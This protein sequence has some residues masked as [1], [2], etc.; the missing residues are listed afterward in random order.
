LRTSL[1]K[2]RRH[3]WSLERSFEKRLKRKESNLLFASNQG[4]IW[5]CH[6]NLQFLIWYLRVF[7]RNICR[8]LNLHKSMG[9]NWRFQQKDVLS[10]RWVFWAEFHW[11]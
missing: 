5:I 9:E 2:P 8:K 3:Q 7:L 1:W 11:T 10:T 4:E 6:S